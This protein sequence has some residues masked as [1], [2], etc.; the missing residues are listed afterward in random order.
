MLKR[1]LFDSKNLNVTV[2]RLCN[3][4]LENHNHFQNSVIIGLQ[5]R[6]IFFAQRIINEIEKQIAKKIQKGY[7]DTTFYRDDYK[8]KRK[9]LDAK[10]T[11]IPFSLDEK[12]VIIVDDV[13]FTHIK[14]LL[15]YLF[16]SL[17][18]NDKNNT[19]CFMF[20]I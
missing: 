6:G 13:L 8:N 4:L 10:E 9:E 5:P 12:N 15:F 7:L 1:L 2:S 17:G 18:G 11:S 20:Y 14:L 19:F 16:N 3:Q